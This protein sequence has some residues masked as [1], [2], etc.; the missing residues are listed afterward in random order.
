M[1]AYV[2]RVVAAGV[3]RKQAEA[4]ADA[5]KEAFVH[6]VEA[7][8]RFIGY[9]LVTRDCLD[10]RFTEFETRVEVN[11]DRRFAEVDKRFDS[12]E[13]RFE[14]IGSKFPRIYLMFGLTMVTATIPILQNFFGQ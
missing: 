1:L 12:L 6:N 4:Q 7:L 11:I 13:L 8:P 5:M 14:R 10:A 3:P 2:R 9:A